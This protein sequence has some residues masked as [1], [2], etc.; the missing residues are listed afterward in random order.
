MK[1]RSITIALAV[2][3]WTVSA[4]A[5][6]PSMHKEKAEKPDCAAM[7]NMDHSKMDADDPVMQAMMKKCMEQM[8]QGDHSAHDNG[9]KAAQDSQEK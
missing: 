7:K 3:A 1:L 5:H 9:E 6:D 4:L 2:S 8:H